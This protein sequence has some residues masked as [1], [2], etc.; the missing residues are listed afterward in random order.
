MVELDAQGPIGSF[1]SLHG[2][3]ND[4]FR[5]IVMLPSLQ[6]G[7]LHIQ[8]SNPDGI[9]RSTLVLLTYTWNS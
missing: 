1:C 3:E 2:L 5:L 6:M 4:D 7:D 9:T 8:T